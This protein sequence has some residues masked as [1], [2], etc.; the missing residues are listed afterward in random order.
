ML[1]VPAAQQR[2]PALSEMYSENRTSPGNR[3]LSEVVERASYTQA[4]FLHD[5]SVEG[6][7]EES[8]FALL[9]SG[10]CPPA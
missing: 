4:W 3:G 8:T 1:R 10:Y 5:M 6:Q 2:G 9:A 7:G